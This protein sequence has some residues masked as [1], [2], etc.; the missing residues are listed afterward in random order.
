RAIPRPPP[1][2]SWSRSAKARRPVGHRG[3]TRRP[4]RS[5]RRPRPRERQGGP[6]AP[7]TD[8]VRHP[9]LRTPK[10]PPRRLARD[11]GPAT[12]PAAAPPPARAERAAVAPDG[13]TP[14]RRPG[15]A[16]PPGTPP[17]RGSR[18]RIRPTARRPFRTSSLECLP[19]QLAGAVQLRLRGPGGHA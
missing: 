5:R 19:E 2:E 13:G 12:S 14:R 16:R 1:P 4:P 10:A 6:I 9:P 11:R 18:P 3:A 17:R 8:G 15:A 7:L